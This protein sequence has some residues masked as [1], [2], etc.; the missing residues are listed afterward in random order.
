MNKNIV[1]KSILEVGVHEALRDINWDQESFQERGGVYE[2]TKD[3]LGAGA[4][5]GCNASA[6]KGIDW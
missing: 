2:W 5:V 6:G 4:T 3:E 1:S